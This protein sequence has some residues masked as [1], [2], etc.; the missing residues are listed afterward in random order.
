VGEGKAGGI[1]EGKGG[2]GKG[3]RGV[4]DKRTDVL[5]A[6]VESWIRQGSFKAG[7]STAGGVLGHAHRR[8]CGRWSIRLH[9]SGVRY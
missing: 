1:G 7:D 4:R 6:N 9:R 5:L 2:S 3:G 8:R